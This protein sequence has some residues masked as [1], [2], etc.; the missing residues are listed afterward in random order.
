M[1]R[2]KRVFWEAK[3]CKPIRYGLFAHIGDWWA[4]RADGEKGAPQLPSQP[5]ESPILLTTPYLDSLNR[6]YQD[7]AYAENLTVLRDVEGALVRRRTLARDIAEHEERARGIQK[8]LDAMA[9]VPDDGVL[10]Q[11]NATEQQADPLLVR[12]R[13]LREYNSVRTKV[14]AAKDRADENIRTQQ[15]KLA[16][17]SETIAVRKRALVIRVARMHAYT[18]RRRS[19]CLRHLL[20][21][22]HEGPKLIVYFDLSS[23]QMPDWLDSWPGDEG[24]VGIWPD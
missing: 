10:A 19:Y 11:R 24:V 15:V 12:A 8:Q 20:R 23:P 5:K 3:P 2:R 16:E 21:K 1:M 22:H 18:M 6:S 7:R 13:R 14:Q 4:A 9:E 17:V